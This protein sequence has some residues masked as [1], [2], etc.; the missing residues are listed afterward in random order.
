MTVMNKVPD[1]QS[2]GLKEKQHGQG[3]KKHDLLVWESERDLLLFIGQ[4][5]KFFPPLV[6]HTAWWDGI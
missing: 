6:E 4:N 1:I 3:E 2:Y 5:Q